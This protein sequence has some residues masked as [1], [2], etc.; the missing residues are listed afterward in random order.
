LCAF[1]ALYF[2]VEEVLTAWCGDHRVGNLFCLRAK[3]A[4]AI[5]TEL[6]KFFTNYGRSKFSNGMHY[7]GLNAGS[8]HTFGSIEIRTLQGSTNPREI[9]EWVSILQRIYEL[10]G[11]YSDPRKVVEGFS[12]EGPMAYLNGVLGPHTNTV[13]SRSSMNT[14]EVM[15]SLYEGIRFAQDLCYCVDWSAIEWVD[16]G[17]DPFNRTPKKSAASLTEF[18]TQWATTLPS[19]EWMTTTQPIYFHHPSPEP[20]EDYPEPDYEEMFDDDED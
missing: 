9:V 13:L 15:R 7:A 1:M 14:Q 3:D 18:V 5:I 20:V 10:S 4:P 8:L 6:K 12:G 11:E 2:S 16:V 17:A 19:E